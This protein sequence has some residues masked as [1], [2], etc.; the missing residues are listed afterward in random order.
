MIRASVS[1]AHRTPEPHG[2]GFRHAKGVTMPHGT[3]RLGHVVHHRTADHLPTETGYQRFN[4]RIA[5]WVT[6]TVGTMT[7]AYLFAALGSVAMYG[8]F[9]NNV[10]L[11]LIAGSISGYFLQLVLLPT[12]IVGQNIAS[13]ASDVR[14]A[15]T[16]EDTE[17]ILDRLDLDTAGGLKIL[18]DEIAA[19]RTAV[20]RGRP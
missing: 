10:T 9:T 13:Q 19:L 2:P 1:Y 12:I 17:T 8:A 4:K 5:V 18:R 14:A 16:F 11:T 15:K 6:T 7:C 20:E 3:T